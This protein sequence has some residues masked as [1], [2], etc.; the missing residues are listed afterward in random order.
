MSNDSTILEKASVVLNVFDKKI[1]IVD[2]IELVCRV[3]STQLA[4]AGFQSVSQETDS[5]SVMETIG[6]LKPDMILLDIFMPHISGL[7]I[8]EKI[9]AD[10]T[11]DHIV[12][13]MLSSAGADEQYQSLELGALGFIQKP[14][15]AVKLVQT[16]T[17]K[18][19][20]AHR[21]GIQ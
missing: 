2:D 12:A 9:R 3:V 21:L 1:L 5:R 10:E 11:N 16:I 15:T 13:L 20:I 19:A 4:S 18:F 17:S 14:I 6:G 8:L 7:E